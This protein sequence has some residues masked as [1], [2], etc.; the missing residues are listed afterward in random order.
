MATDSSGMFVTE[1]GAPDDETVMEA[2][3][4][5]FVMIS[6]MCAHTS[7]GKS[8]E[9]KYS[10]TKATKEK[11]SAETDIAL[12]TQASAS[13]QDSF[14]PDLDLLL[15]GKTGIGKSAVG[16]SILG[17]KVFKSSASANSKTDKISADV[18]KVK[19]Q[20][21]K[22][23]DSPGVGDTR[24]D[25]HDGIRLCMDSIQHAMITNPLG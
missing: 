20:I 4:E 9:E 22:V 7:D 3:T 8:L 13:A 2:D 19:G 1:A 24:M 15:I 14:T 21:I 23:V 12:R 5:G 17:R 18:A 16:N 11:S 6:K 25:T 10:A